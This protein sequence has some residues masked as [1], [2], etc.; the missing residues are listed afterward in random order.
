MK[1]AQFMKMALHMTIE[2]YNRFCKRNTKNINE[3]DIYIEH[4]IDNKEVL[5]S[6]MYVKRNP[7]KKY[8]VSYDKKT[9]KVS[10]Y[11]SMKIDDLL[12]KEEN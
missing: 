5:V 1:F 4:T 6:I 7:R 2:Y 10:S 11:I 12:K 9:K 3:E 8:I